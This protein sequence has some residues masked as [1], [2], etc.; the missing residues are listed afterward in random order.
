MS[1]SLCFNLKP[2][3]KMK[4]N[5]KF[6][7]TIGLI[8]SIISL[9]FNTIMISENENK[10]NTIS[11]EIAY[12]RIRNSSLYSDFA[13]AEHQEFYA[14]FYNIWTYNLIKNGNNKEDTLWIRSILQKRDASLI[15]SINYA[16]NSTVFD[17]T[18]NWD[19]KKKAEIQ[20][21][22]YYYNA[23]LKLPK[24]KEFDKKKL[25]EINEKYSIYEK[26]CDS[27]IRHNNSVITEF[28]NKNIVLNKWGIWYRSLGMI[29][30][31]V[32][33]LLIFLKDH[34]KE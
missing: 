4:T 25:T 24:Y 31:V 11:N 29:F 5:R 27:I 13:N 18:K 8:I 6:I 10:R 16:C 34:I 28:T 15:K 9:I 30:Q 14:G 32:G 22:V 7:V 12:Y 20:S 17:P 26:A 3:G 23:L 19:E 1:S 2:N 21:L 33:L